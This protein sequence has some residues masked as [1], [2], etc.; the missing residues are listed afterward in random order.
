MKTKAPTGKPTLIREIDFLSYFPTSLFKKPRPSQKEGLLALNGRTGITMIQAGTGSGK[1][2]LGYTYLHALAEN[3]W[4]GLVMVEPR[5]VLVEQIAKQHPDIAV[6]YG[7]NEYPCFY[8]GDKQYQ[9]DEIP[10]SM[11][12]DCPHRVDQTT[13]QTKEPGARPCQYL[14]AKFQA[15]QAKISAC[16]TAFFLY[17]QLYNSGNSNWK[18]ISAAVIGE[19]HELG[20]VIRNC[21]SHEITDYHLEQI[22][23]LLGSIGAKDDAKIFEE[24]YLLMVETIR[25]RKPGEKGVLLDEEILALVKILR[26]LKP[27]RIETSV[28]QAIREKRIDP[29]EKMEAMKGVENVARN[30]TTYLRSL[31]YSVEKDD[32][33]PLNYTYGCYQSERS[34]QPNQ[35]VKY[36]LFIKSYYV[37]PA[38]ERILPKEVL[39]TS[40][41]I[42]D[43][44]AYRMDTGI[45]GGFIDL[46]S[47]FP[48]GNSRIYLPTD[49]LDLSFKSQRRDS[50]KKV[51][52]R[53]VMDMKML[54]CE[55]IRSLFIVVSHEE[56]ELTMRYSKEFGLKTITY[57]SEI[58]SRQAL[59]MFKEGHGEALLGTAASYGQGIDLPG[60]L[61]PVIFFLRPSY[62]PPNDP[63]AIFEER[64]HGKLVWKLR[65]WRAMTEALQVRG[66]NVRDKDDVGATIFISQQF[67]KFLYGCLPK[68]LQPAFVNKFKLAGAMED[69][70]KVVMSNAVE[71]K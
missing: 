21:L 55:G 35:R 54:A 28:K 50:V 61:A 18:E 70:M 13:G 9:A 63:Q 60:K 67:K 19:G 7:R 4:E 58:N 26:K 56:R 32:R 5:K 44:H 2:A 37:A 68:W 14:L 48:V 64:R 71:E 30:I 51:I 59:Q 39:I 27:S 22:I 6:V 43:P 1:T 65:I 40:A 42:G 53:T 66:R 8:Y 20:P 10:C 23:E 33:R 57:G 49:T 34:M 47:D 3:G 38:I 69:A 45:R 17:Q 25:L 41:T 11:L 46:G 29:A 24:F 31:E 36:R 62:P 15:K 52:K 16:T 12:V